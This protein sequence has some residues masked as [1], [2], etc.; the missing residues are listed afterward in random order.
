MVRLW[1][2]VLRRWGEKEMDRKN[3]IKE[4]LILTA[5]SALGASAVYFFMVPG[6]IVMGSVAGAAMILSHYIPVSIAIMNFLLNMLCLIL[7]FLLVGKEF[8]AKTVYISIIIPAIMRFYELIFP[9]ITSLTDN[10]VLDMICMIII[11][12][13]GQAILF[14]ANSSSGG[15]DIIA[16]II[17]KYFHIGLGQAVT[18]AGGLVILSSVFVFDTKTLIVGILATYFNGLVINEYIGGFTKKKKVCIISEKYEGIQKFIVSDIRRGTTLYP[19]KGGFSDKEYMELVTILDK[20]EYGKV[21]NY[22]QK[23]DPS[24]FVTVS[25]VSEVVG[26]WNRGGRKI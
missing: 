16:K 13:M 25:T 15:L 12:S 20:N 21:M 5:G 22:I 7:G 10:I 11:A 6:N 8:G 26:M 4:Y 2:L 14:H 24:A 17:N 23:E 1:R 19:V 3:K 18:I 9:D